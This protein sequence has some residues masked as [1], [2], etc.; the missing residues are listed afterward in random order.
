MPGFG[1]QS[2]GLRSSTI[3]EFD[4]MNHLE[5]VTAAFGVSNEFDEIRAKRDKAMPPH[6]AQ[7]RLGLPD[8]YR[9]IVEGTPSS[10]PSFF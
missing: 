10:T 8:D 2:V 7:V 5:Y 6:P 3:E 9:H 4:V 1:M